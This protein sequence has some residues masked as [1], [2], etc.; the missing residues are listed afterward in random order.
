MQE[1]KKLEIDEDGHLQ[2][3]KKIALYIRGRHSDLHVS[4]ALR[5]LK[6]LRIYNVH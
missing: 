5:R 6:G 3:Y 2:F 4:T 1:I